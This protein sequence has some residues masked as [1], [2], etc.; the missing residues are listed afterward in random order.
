MN[1]YFQYKLEVRPLL[2]DVRCTEKSI[3]DL[4]ACC[5]REKLNIKTEDISEGACLN[6]LKKVYN[7]ILSFAPIY[8]VCQDVIV[9]H[10]F[11]FGLSPFIYRCTNSIPVK[12]PDTRTW[13]PAGQA[14]YSDLRQ[15]KSNMFALCK[16]TRLIVVRDGGGDS[17]LNYDRLGSSKIYLPHASFA[18]AVEMLL[19][20]H[21]FKL[22]TRKDIYSIPEGQASQFDSM[23][24]EEPCTELPNSDV[25]QEQS[26]VNKSI[27]CL[28]TSNDFESCKSVNII[29][30]SLEE[31]TQDLIISLKDAGGEI[32]VV[33][34]KKKFFNSFL[35]LNAYTKLLGLLLKA[36]GKSISLQGKEAT[37]A[38]RD[39]ES[40]TEILHGHIGSASLS[41]PYHL[42]EFKSRLRMAFKS[43]IRAPSEVHL[44]SA[45]QTIERALV[46][47]HE[48]Y[49]IVYDINTGNVDVGKVSSTVAAGIDYLDLVLEY[50]SGPLISYGTAMGSDRDNGPDPG[51]VILIQTQKAEMQDYRRRSDVVYDAFTLNP[52]PYPVLLIFAVIAFLFWIPWYLNHKDI[53]GTAEKQVN[54]LIFLVP[55]VIIAIV[56]WL[57]N[58]AP[59]DRR[60]RTYQQPSE[61]SSPWGVAAFI[62]L[63]LFLVRYQ[64]SGL[65]SWFVRRYNS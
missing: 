36:L 19:C 55:F 22:A 56:G 12:F 64:S 4:L 3:D 27:P 65:E 29:A 49:P 21:E 47:I 48:G 24:A 25:A 45:I 34:W 2:L 61:G 35:L 62:V 33:D 51:A 14:L 59:W 37:L 9:Y 18:K 16:A 17:E 43:L 42:D 7:A 11:L 6:F 13:M 15:E 44:L 5:L 20:S 40:S 57:F 54:W 38:S 32:D 53:A 30:E 41:H 52:L 60:R 8:F 39:K 26:T 46:V 1:G 28:D 50:V 63:I 10:A 23:I 58:M 31:Q